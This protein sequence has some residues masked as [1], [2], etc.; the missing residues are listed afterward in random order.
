MNTSQNTKDESQKDSDKK[1]Y[2]VIDKYGV[3]S[4]TN[5]KYFIKD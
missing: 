2:I 3:V 5:I 4:L 1:Q